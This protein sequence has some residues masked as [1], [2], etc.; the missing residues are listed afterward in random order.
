MDLGLKN[1]VALLAASSKGLGKAVA[2]T[3]AKEGAKLV[4]CA[5]E[6]TALEKTA[7]DL[8]L[9][10][11]V[12]VFPLAVDLTDGKQ[13]DW[14]IKET[15]DLFGK[16]DILVVNAGGPAP[17]RFNELSETD[18]AKAYELTLLSAARLVS[19]V[20]P[21]M[22][23]QKWGRIVF[24]T[25]VTAK[26]PLAGLTLSNVMR[27]AV[28]GLARDLARDLAPDQIL[29]NAVCPG[30]FSTERLEQLIKDKAEAR[31]VGADKIRDE[32]ALEAPLGRIGKP[33][34]FA[35]LVAYLV[36][37]RASYITGAV[38]PVDGG[39]LRGM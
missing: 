27:P 19:K 39:W 23:R 26:E 6:K 8:F 17:G 10:T 33:E 25:S 20:V 36:S 32:M 30:Y 37:D 12:T 11:G 16:I 15:M 13:I 38:I 28:V 5:R 34:E 31:H 3:L 35:D 14:L 9:S 4:I 22:R 2:W 24:M 7:D 21:S 1:R 18:W 29:V